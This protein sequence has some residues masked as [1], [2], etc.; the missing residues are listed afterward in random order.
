MPITNNISLDA[1]LSGRPKDLPDT[2]MITLKKGE[3]LL[4]QGEVPEYLYILAT[5]TLKAF[6]SSSDAKKYLLLI[7]KSGEITGEIE[8]FENR[9]CVCTV[10]ALE[11]CTLL[12][13]SRQDFLS[14]FERD[15]NFAFYVNQHFCKK[16][17]MMIQKTSSDILYSL[18]ARFLALLRYDLCASG[19]ALRIDKEQIAEQL[20]TSVRSINR[21]IRELEEMHVLL[22]KNGKIQL[23]SS[24]PAAQL[25]E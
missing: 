6:L 1:L 18:Q 12:R 2:R 13:V 14:W 19:E 4:R 5:G 8:L 24:E 23:L 3:I 16:L 11:D 15:C 10:E 20:G 25:E 9:P 22:Y 17:Y 7:H 21:I